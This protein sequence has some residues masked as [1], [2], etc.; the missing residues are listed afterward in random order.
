MRRRLRTFLRIAALLA[1]SAL[2]AAAA[3]SVAYEY[4]Q[5][6]RLAR[7]TQS[8]GTV[9]EYSYDPAGNRRT[10]VVAGPGLDPS[11]SSTRVVILPLSG[12][13]VIPLRDPNCSL[14]AGCG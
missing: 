10:R 6:G 9:I 1:V 14:L 13:I 2:P 5:L 8:D 3:Q 11:A 7:V 12:F 4:D